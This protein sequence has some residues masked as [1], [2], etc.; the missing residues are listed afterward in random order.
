MTEKLSARVFSVISE[1]QAA[2]EADELKKAERLLSDLLDGEKGLNDYERAQT[3][4]F[5]AAVYYERGDIARAIADYIAITELENPPQQI[6]HNSFF[7]LAQLYFMEEDYEQSVQTLDTWMGLQS[8][9]IRPEA[10]ML[11]AQAYYQQGRFEA[12]EAPILSALQEAKVRKQ[13]LRESWLALLRAVYYEQ[14]RYP[15]AARVL[16]VLVEH[17]PSASYYRQWAGM[18]GLMGQQTSRLHVLRAAYVKGMLESESDLLNLARLYMSMDIP[19]PAMGVLQAGMESGA[20]EESAANLQ[21]LAQ[22]M[23]LARESEAQIAVLEQAAQ[24]SGEAKHYMYLGQAHIALYHWKAAADAFNKALAI[25]GLDNP[26]SVLM[27]MGSAYF[28][29]KAYGRSL[30]AFEQA[31]EYDTYRTQAL[32]WVEFVQREVERAQLIGS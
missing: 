8:G 21:L 20:I 13:P 30:Q 24:L 17:W 22:A 7:R 2:V 23:S 15:E 12:A 14:E 3:H 31:A 1:A 5:R 11:K 28:Q 10:H 32:Q 4:N 16:G 29:M 9:S 25:G 27:Q 6:L 18:L 26:G 19:Y